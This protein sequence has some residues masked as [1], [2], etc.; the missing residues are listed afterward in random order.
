MTIDH[1]LAREVTNYKIRQKKQRRVFGDAASH[2]ARYIRF[3]SVLTCNVHS[4]QSLGLVPTIVMEICLEVGG[5]D[6]AQTLRCLLLPQRRIST[7]GIFLEDTSF[8]SGRH[9]A[10][11][12]S[13]FY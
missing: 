7:V 12:L 5:G 13:F 6:D 10:D 4:F 11:F 3:I 9:K 2:L 1:I 8:E